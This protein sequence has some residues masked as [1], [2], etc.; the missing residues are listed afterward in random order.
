MIELLLFAMLVVDS[1]RL[2]YLGWR[3][4]NLRPSE[5]EWPNGRSA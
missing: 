4:T 3:A 2:D 1:A 5:L